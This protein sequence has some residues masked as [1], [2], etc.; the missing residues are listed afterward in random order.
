VQGKRS[1]SNFEIGLDSNQQH[2]TTQPL[3]AVGEEPTPLNSGHK[4]RPKIG[5]QIAEI[6]YQHNMND[7]LK[8]LESATLPP[9]INYDQTDL[10]TVRIKKKI[11]T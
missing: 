8:L 4:T 7:T 6:V 1:S 3:S 11:R 10:P 9:S 2:I 5:A